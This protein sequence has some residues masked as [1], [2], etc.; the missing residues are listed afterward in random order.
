[1][2]ILQPFNVS[3][4]HLSAPT[5]NMQPPSGAPIFYKISTH[6]KVSMQ[7]FAL[8]L[9][10]KNWNLGYCKLLN[11]FKLPTLENRR[12]H[13][14]LCTLF[15]IVH[16]LCSLNRTLPLISPYSHN[17]RCLTFLQPFARTV[18]FRSSFFPDA[19]SYWNCLPECVVS[20]PSYHVFKEGLRVF[21]S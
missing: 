11:L 10:G 21:T 9:C 18:A 17:T 13:L 20:S 1:M 4:F 12:L 16:N 6:W 3:T 15:K 5:W 8:R 2:L 19:I 7:K 14:K